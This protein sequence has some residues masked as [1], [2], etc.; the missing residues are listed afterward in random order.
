[1]IALRTGKIFPRD[2]HDTAKFLISEDKLEEAAE[3]CSS[4]GSPFGRMLYACLTRADASGYEM[5]AALEE[6]GSRILYDLRSN[7]QPLGIIADVSPLLGLMGTVLGMIKAFE[8][9]ARTGALGRAELLAQGFAEALLTTAFGLAVAVPAMFF[10]QFFRSKA[11]GLVRQME[12][13]CI[14]ILDDLRKRGKSK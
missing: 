12:D 4:D 8:V 9:V 1:M 5:E 2:L 6:S 10:F 14:D 3:A 13:A 11:D 7:S